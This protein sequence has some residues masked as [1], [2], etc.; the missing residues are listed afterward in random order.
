MQSFLPPPLKKPHKTTVG[1]R[2]PN[3]SVVI[4]LQ[5]RRALATNGLLFQQAR[6]K[7]G[8][9]RTNHSTYELKA[10]GEARWIKQRRISLCQHFQAVSSWFSPIAAHRYKIGCRAWLTPNSFFLYSFTKPDLEMLEKHL[11]HSLL[12]EGRFYYNYCP[13]IVEV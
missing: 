10:A 5:C 9:L 6:R 3:A 12:Q 7:H 4:T 13:C 11:W 8:G 1:N 2:L